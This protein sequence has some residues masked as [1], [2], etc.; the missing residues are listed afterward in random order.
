MG[1][2]LGDQGE[3]ALPWS[4]LHYV[5]EAWK[6]VDRVVPR[7]TV[8]TWRIHVAHG[9]TVIHYALD[10]AGR[11]PDTRRYPWTGHDSSA[12]CSQPIVKRGACSGQATVAHVTAGVFRGR[13]VRIGA[14]VTAS[15]TTAAPAEEVPA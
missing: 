14:G 10:N 13:W 3:A 1:R 4:Q 6:S 8:T 7:P 11:L 15:S 12:P 2:R 5:R 9:A